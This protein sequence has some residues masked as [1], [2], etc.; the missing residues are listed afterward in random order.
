MSSPE[1]RVALVEDHAALRAGLAMLL[2]SEGFAIAGEAGD[3]DAGYELVGRE[4]PDVVVLDVMLPGENGI[5]LTKRMLRRD[6]RLGVLLYTASEDPK[7]L[8]RVLECGA[9]GVAH[10]ASS[11]QETVRAVR[12]IAAGGTYVD[13]RVGRI[14]A[15]SATPAP[16]RVL[17]LR[18]REVLSLVAQGLSRS[19]LSER[20]SI[21]EETTRTH[22]RN[23]MRKLGAHTRAQ[24]I[25]IAL[26]NG[27]IEV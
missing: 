5:S 3:A 18:E 15:A 26:R 24:A 21:S 19:E 13:A 4:R 10:K 16:E 12:A 9:R 23:A 27:E 20:L 25:V 8:S 22:V 17:S 14:I 7:V 6:S 1:R 2:A 11:L